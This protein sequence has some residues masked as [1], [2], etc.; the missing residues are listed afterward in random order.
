MLLNI[1]FAERCF[2]FLNKHKHWNWHRCFWPSGFYWL[3]KQHKDRGQ[4]SRNDLDLGRG[5][6]LNSKMCKS[7]NTK[8][9]KQ[10]DILNCSLTNPVIARLPDSPTA[11][12]KEIL[13][14]D[15][16][17]KWALNLHTDWHTHWFSENQK[18]KKERFCPVTSSLPGADRAN[19]RRW[20]SERGGRWMDGCGGWATLL[21]CHLTGRA[22][23]LFISNSL[24]FA[25]S[26][27]SPLSPLFPNVISSFICPHLT[28]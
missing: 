25:D 2:T 1:F 13:L 15:R 12:M 6:I 22:A 24:L 3:Y 14:T 27:F 10:I 17:E 18:Q 16:S 9:P 5:E 28:P 8:W 26:L 7:R 11:A 19:E 20:K 23:D 4:W 21:L